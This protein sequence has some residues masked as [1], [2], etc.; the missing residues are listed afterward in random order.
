M[1]QAYLISRSLV[2]FSAA[3][4][5]FAQLIQALQSERHLEREHGNIEALIW[6]DG[7]E[8]LRRMCKGT[9]ICARPGLPGRRAKTKQPHHTLGGIH[10][11]APR[12]TR[13]GLVA[14]IMVAVDVFVPQRAVLAL[15]HL[16]AQVLEFMPRTRQHRRGLGLAPGDARMNG[17][18]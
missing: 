12:R 13:Q 17:T 10:E 9:W 14:Q 18:G 16:Q 15:H 1:K 5:Q 11:V 8:L 4:E 6:Q 2:E 7:Q 3:R